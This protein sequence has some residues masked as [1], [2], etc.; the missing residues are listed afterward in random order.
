M[1]PPELLLP[2]EPVPTPAKTA[3]DRTSD[4]RALV[5]TYRMPPIILLSV[6]LELGIILAVALTVTW[7][8]GRASSANELRGGEMEWLTSSAYMSSQSLHQLGYIPRWEPWLAF[9]E[10]LVDNPFSFVTNPISVGPS[11]IWGA[12]VGIRFSVILS[13]ILAAIGGWTLGRVLGFGWLAR[14]LLGLLCLG[15]GNMIAMIGTGYFQLGVTQA[16]FPW[17]LAGFIG[18]LRFNRRRWPIVLT[19]IMFTLM[20]WAGN[21]WYTLPM[22][23]MLGLLTLSHVVHVKRTVAPNERPTL[24]VKI[25]R[26]TLNRV[27]LSAGLTLGLS[28]MTLLPIWINQSRIGGHPN[29]TIGDTTADLGKIL[30]LVGQSAP[31]VTNLHGVDTGLLWKLFLIVKTKFSR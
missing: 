3:A 9:G 11:L 18:V 23:I 4:S 8:F 13:T 14:L 10:P 26:T 30:S 29:A 6:L 20:F 22:I 31:A 27:L 1:T 17:I 12:L 19:A 25:D 7:S 2:V 5:A 15:K 16:Y 28:M 24:A 21:I